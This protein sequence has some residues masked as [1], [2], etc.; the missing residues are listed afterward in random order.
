MS[1]NSHRTVSISSLLYSFSVL[2][3]SMLTK[4]RC[5]PIAL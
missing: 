3:Q 4:Y 1:I 2:M 5:T